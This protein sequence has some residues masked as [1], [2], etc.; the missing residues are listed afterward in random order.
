L[1]K[2]AIIGTRGIP[3]S[4]SGFE[5]SVEETAIR[6]VELN[7][8][9]TVYCRLNYYKIRPKT[10]KGVN[11]VHLPSIKTKY[12]DTISHTFLTLLHL[13]RKK[14][15]NVIIYGIGNAI[16]IPFIRMFISN[17]IIVVDGADW[18]RKKWNVIAK[19]YFIINRFIATRFSNA[20]VVDNEKL[21]YDYRKKYSGNGFFI[22]YGAN[23]IKE[24]NPNYLQTYD[25]MRNQ[26]LIF[27]GRF[28][29]EKNIEFLIE[30]FKKLE[31]NIK[32]LIIGGNDI[33][34]LYCEKIKSLKNKNI[35]IP[36][37]LY[38]D[39]Y[40]TLLKDA[41]FYVSCSL[42]EGTSPSLLSAMSIN[43][44]AI[45]SNLDENKETLKGSCET[46][47]QGNGKDF[48]DK[49]MY[50]I[51]HPELIEK[52]KEKTKEIINNHYNWESIAKQYY[53]LFKI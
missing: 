32:L 4:Y 43:G 29:K 21:L 30:N 44:F 36:G 11:L 41:L 28:V 33:D 48:R 15:N 27:I 19:K 51:N 49:V 31:T 20:Y 50:F 7:C 35:I 1:I 10:Y 9:T 42:L 16:F 6:L 8:D 38:G 52:E 39:I 26:Y 13:F 47:N 17:I 3:A 45:V 24:Y 53:D 5:T 25:L 14:Y 2:L 34:G 37:F 12:L 18:E 40:E 46:Y 23:K 22:S